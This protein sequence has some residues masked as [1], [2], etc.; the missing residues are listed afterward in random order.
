MAMVDVGQ[1]PTGGLAAQV[2]W[3]RL[4]VGSRLAQTYI[5]QI[6]G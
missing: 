6:T 3:L 1:Q 4:R 2:G 5:R